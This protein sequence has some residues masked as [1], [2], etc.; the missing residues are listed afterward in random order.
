MPG[1]PVALRQPA[2]DAPGHGAPV[3]LRHPVQDAPGSAP[4]THAASIAYGMPVAESGGLADGMAAPRSLMPA[5]VRAPDLSAVASEQSKYYP[6]VVVDATSGTHYD[7][8]SGRPTDAPRREPELDIVWDPVTSMSTLVARYLCAFAGV[9]TMT[10]LIAHAY[11]EYYVLTLIAA[12]FV[13]GVLLPIMDVVPKQRDDSD[14]VWIFMGLIMLFGP[15]I[16][17]VIYGVIGLLRQS[18]NPAIIGCFVVS[19][20]IQIAVYL[21]AGPTLL[22][23]G[24]PWVQQGFDV[25]TLL[26]NWCAFASLAGWA[27]ANVFHRFDE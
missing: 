24:P 3:I 8:G 12:M 5:D 22:L 13:S 19:I 15:A 18:A 7:A 20:V 17:L 23:F 21:S 4:R 2:P 27:S 1:P 10:C 14:D 6:G 26:V 11:K 9:V 16:G 25:R